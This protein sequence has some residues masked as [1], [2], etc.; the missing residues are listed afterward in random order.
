M[1]RFLAGLTVAALVIAA[2]AS[3][4]AAELIGNDLYADCTA[5]RNSF[6]SG[7]CAGYVAGITEAMGAG[8]SFQ[9]FSACFPSSETL[10]QKAD[11]VA[12]FLTSHPDKRH[13]AAAALVA[14]ALANA[15]PCKR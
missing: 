3:V 1:R 2:S 8:A 6:G 14:E 13:R 9:G 10:A 15:Y 5:P 4:S 11:A 12:Q 7:W